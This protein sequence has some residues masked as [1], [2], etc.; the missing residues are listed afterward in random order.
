MA[1]SKQQKQEEALQRKRAA[2]PEQIASWRKHQRGGE[3]YKVT[4]EWD[5]VK[6][7]DEEAAEAEKRLVKAAAEAGLDRYGNA[8][9]N[10]R[11]VPEHARSVFN[12]ETFTKRC[13]EGGDLYN[14][15]LEEK[16][17]VAADN[18]A[19]EA[20]RVME[21]D[22]SQLCAPGIPRVQVRLGRQYDDTLGGA[23][24]DP[25]S[26]WVPPTETHAMSLGQLLMAGRREPPPM[27]EMTEE[28]IRCF[29]DPEPGTDPSWD[30]LTES[31]KNSFRWMRNH[32]E[33]A[34]QFNNAKTLGELLK[35]REAI[36]MPESSLSTLL[37]NHI[38][39]PRNPN[40]TGI[41]DYPEH[42]D[43]DADYTLANL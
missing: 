3:F 21:Q 36:D 9:I 22:T 17:R 38:S 25:G 10:G 16:G 43:D 34:A 6:A 11:T 33:D 37:V 40:M 24:K 20:L 12:I 7:A 35:D 26:L 28:E 5:S 15:E 23:G 8:L 30:S 27:V 39:G 41:Y 14:T 1:K 31:E 4:V 29:G 18:M 13:Q 2:F 42:F 32:P 19:K